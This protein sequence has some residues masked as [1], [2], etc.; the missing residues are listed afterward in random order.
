MIEISQNTLLLHPKRHGKGI[1]TPESEKYEEGNIFQH[2]MPKFDGT[3]T[4]FLGNQT[5]IAVARRTTKRKA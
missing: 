2:K 4:S 1:F 5:E 3:N